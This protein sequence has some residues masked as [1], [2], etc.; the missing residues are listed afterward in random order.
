[1]VIHNRQIANLFARLAD[2]MELDGANP[3]RV[4]SYRQAAQ[5]IAGLS[6]TLVKRVRNGEDLTDL[7]SIGKSIAE[8]IATIVETGRL[9]QLEELEKRMPAELS[10]VMRL[11]GLG[12][13][14]VK[15]LHQD[16]GVDSLA[17]LERVVERHEVRELPGFGA[18]TEQSIGERLARWEGAERRTPLPQAEEIAR[19]LLDYLKAIDGIKDLTIAGSYRRRKDTLGDLDILVTATQGAPVME[20]F[21]GYDEVRE[22]VTQGQARSTVILSSGM[23]V[24]LRRVPQLSYGAALH[25]FTGS[26]SHN[27]AVRRMGV[28]KG[29]KIN[30]Y[31][32]FRGD[33]R[34]GGR[35]EEQVYESIDLPYIEP[36]L[37][38]NQ[39]EID[40]AGEGKLPHLVTLADIQGDLH[41]HT[42]A[43]DGYDSLETMAEGAAKCGYAYLAITDHSQHLTVAHGLDERRLA[44][45]INEIDRLND[46]LDGRI[47]L[48]KAIELDI[49]EDGTLD[50]PDTILKQLDLRVCSVH[51]KFDLPRNK[52]TERIQR[53]MESPYFN[54][55]AHPTGRLIGEREAYEVDLEKLIEAAA[56]HGC[57]LEVNAQPKRLD[58][59]PAGCRLAKEAGVKVAISTD[60]PG[61]AR[62]V[63][64]RWQR[65]AKAGGK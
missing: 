46:K 63:D 20:R 59:D 44:A 54:I 36:E 47:E 61:M 51:Y 41:A 43:S 39:G 55:L 52:Q 11:S 10:E 31:G 14:R 35:T 37:R 7:P 12:S 4:R 65:K 9:P 56:K 19:S 17:D 27:I 30:E 22:I 38:E 33:K 53:A 23:Q 13:Q 48:L 64:G 25:Y 28:R 60:A 40:A 42:R 62:S 26:K 45:Q 5:T 15:L 58:L 2:L 50:L 24:D 32:V 16:L 1:M 29:L 21:V 3:F 8:K 18:K 57:F 34:V 6:D 49:L